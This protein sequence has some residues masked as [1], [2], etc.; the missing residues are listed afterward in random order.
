MFSGT[1]SLH[2][3]SAVDSAAGFGLI[4]GRLVVGA[5]YCEGVACVEL[6]LL[7]CYACA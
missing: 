3:M 7:A 1:F 2:G 4:A 6:A 5:S